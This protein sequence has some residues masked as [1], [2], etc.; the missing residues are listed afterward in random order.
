[1]IR[2]RTRKSAGS[3]MNLICKKTIFRFDCNNKNKTIT[4]ALHFDI[5]FN[6]KSETVIF[7]MSTH[8][9]DQ[10]KYLK[11]RCS[12]FKCGRMR[13]LYCMETRRKHGWSDRRKK[14]SALCAVQA[15]PI[16]SNWMMFFLCFF[17]LFLLFDSMFF[18]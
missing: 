7:L 12:K 17:L 6:V 16:Q 13:M 14:V 1:M 4:R 9:T 5:Q 18:E 3:R 8:K 11:L 15:A 2:L 10:L